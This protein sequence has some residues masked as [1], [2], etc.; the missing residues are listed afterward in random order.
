MMLDIVVI[1]GQ[2]KPDVACESE[3]TPLTP[4]QNFRD[5]HKLLYFSSPRRLFVGRINFAKSAADAAAA[6]SRVK[7]DAA[8]ARASGVLRASDEL[9]AIFVVT[10]GIG[11]PYIPPFAKQV[12]AYPILEFSM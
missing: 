4:G 1:S 12:C 2:L 5:F 3:A 10:G 7:T 6:L 8:A 9:Q 11:S